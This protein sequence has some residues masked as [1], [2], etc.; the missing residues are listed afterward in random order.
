MKKSE[1][2]EFGIRKKQNVKRND[3]KS[4]KIFLEIKT[5]PKKGY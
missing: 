1:K 3:K 5:D 4:G 2:N